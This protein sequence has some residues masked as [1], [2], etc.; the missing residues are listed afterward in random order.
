MVCFET[1]HD[2]TEAVHCVKRRSLQLDTHLHER[3]R[4]Q[5]GS[6]NHVPNCYQYQEALAV[7]FEHSLIAQS[8]HGLVL[9]HFDQS[10]SSRW[11]HS[12][13]WKMNFHAR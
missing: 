2:T 5:S 11:I 8:D 1:K 3:S 12:T 13:Q 4:Y 9:R 6:L 10:L 7:G